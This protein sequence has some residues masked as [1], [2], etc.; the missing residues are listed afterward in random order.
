MAAEGAEEVAGSAE[1]V[2]AHPARGSLPWLTSP[3]LAV[4]HQDLSSV[5]AGPVTSFPIVTP[6]TVRCLSL[7]S[8]L[9]REL[10]FS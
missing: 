3:S 10:R 2:G 6:P 8:V 1:L 9:A 5:L 4:G 7:A